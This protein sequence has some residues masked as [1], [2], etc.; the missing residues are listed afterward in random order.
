[1]KKSGADLVAYALEQVGVKFTFGIPGVHNTEIYDALARSETLTPLLV[2]HEQCASFMADAVSRTSNSVG[3][4]V[5]VPAAGMTHA[6]SGIGEAYLDG[7]PLLAISGGIRRDTGKRYQLHELDQAKVL[8]GITKGAFLVDSHDKVI[9]TIFQA[10]E[11]A[12]SGEPGP[13]F[14]EISGDV[15]LFSGEVGELPRY[16]RKWHPPVPDAARIRDAVA[17][18]RR[19][20]KVGL[21]LGW[22]ARDATTATVRLAELLGAPVATTLQGISV[23]PHDHPLHAGFG[24]GASAVPAAQKAFEDIDCLVAIGC[25]F[26]ELA[27]GSYGMPVPA[28]LIHA[29][30]N[31]KVFGANY[32]AKVAVET[33]ASLFADAL[34]RALEGDGVRAPDRADVKGKIARDKAS[35]QQSWCDKASA[36][37]VSPGIFF[38]ELRRSL[39]RDAFV[40]L[41]DGNHTFLAAEQYPVYESKHLISPTDFNCMG[42][43][44]P[45]TIATKLANPDSQVCA[46][47]G[48][49][50]FM[51]TALEILTAAMNKLGAV[52]FVFHDGEL[53]QISQF[54]YIPLKYKTCTVIGDIRF[55]GIATATGAAYLRMQ[56]DSDV[57]RVIGEA[58]ALAAQG[59]PVIVDVNID[60]SRRSAFTS[61]V[62]KT[63]L[64]RFP[65]SE[66]LRFV[67]RA[68]KRHTVG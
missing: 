68:I 10:Y 64:S 31:P 4:I 32:P 5:V 28:N 11:L 44:V 40:V 43:C 65:L 3:C 29:D 58:L 41:D 56:S 20:K 21:Y 52:F 22:G 27:T 24:F 47:V 48:D 25:R 60:Y 67:G 35:F 14:V 13:V 50:A 34:V 33:D 17:L 26:A 39:D 54:Q 30:I 63:N 2:T 66:K 37:K 46:I 1:M 36:D 18:I 59:A 9:P 55:E 15:Q 16:V 19:S 53:A 49:G 7:I 23:F 12:T 62:V 61:G 57:T 38:R 6:M 45:A 51:M 8:D 42:Y